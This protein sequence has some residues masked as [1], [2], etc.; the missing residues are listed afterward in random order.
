M[1]SRHRPSRAYIRYKGRG[2]C[3]ICRE[4]DRLRHEKE[5]DAADRLDLTHPRCGMGT[6]K[7]CGLFF[8]G[9]HYAKE[10]TGG[11]CT[12]SNHDQALG[13]NMNREDFQTGRPAK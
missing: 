11:L 9:E 5:V 3:P 6:R 4:V 7:G 1:P 12:R 13:A 10:G 2:L 8:G